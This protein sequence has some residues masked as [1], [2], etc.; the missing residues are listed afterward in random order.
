MVKIQLLTEIKTDITILPAG[1]LVLI[2]C[3][4]A[5][6]LIRGGLAKWVDDSRRRE[7][8]MKITITT[9]QLESAGIS[10][11]SAAYEKFLAEFGEV[12]EIEWTPDKQL[13]ALKDPVWRG[14]LGLAWFESIVPMCTMKRVDLSGADL[15]GADL[16]EADLRQ[17][18]LSGANLSRGN[19][20]GANL[21][22]S[23]LRKANLNGVNLRRTYLIGADLCGA[24]LNGANLNEANLIEADLSGVDLRGA[25]MNRVYLSGKDLRIAGLGIADLIGLYLSGADLC[26]DMCGANLSGADLTNAD[27]IGTN[28]SEAITNEHTIFPE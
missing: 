9:K 16:K 25:T 27:L 22:G 15:S 13:E 18:D 23:N 17:A 1:K 11:G 6:I 19:L 3:K 8:E 24:N 21:N 5:H 12:L 10:E 4:D 26:I 28:L 14:V 7:T 20:S 2:N